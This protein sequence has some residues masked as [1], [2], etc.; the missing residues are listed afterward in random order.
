MA[1][2]PAFQFYT[3]DWLKDPNLGQCRPATRGIW[4]DL[5]CL[6]HENNKSGMIT[7]TPKSL[8]RICRATETEIRDALTDLHGTDTAD[9]QWADGEIV[10]VMNRR[11]RAED[12]LRRGG[13]ERQRKLR[14]KGGGDPKRWTAIRVPILKRDRYMCAYCGKK[15][16]TVDH[17]TPKSRGG[18]EDSWN[19]VACCK[20]CNNKKVDRT[21]EEAGMKFWPSFDKN[22]IKITPPSSSSSSS[23]PSDY[24]QEHDEKPDLAG[25]LLNAWPQIQAD[26]GLP[27]DAIPDV[28]R[29]TKNSAED[30]LPAFKETLAWA[31]E[32]YGGYDALRARLLE[33]VKAHAAG[34]GKIYSLKSL[35]TNAE[36]MGGGK[37]YHGKV[38]R[39]KDEYER[40]VPDWAK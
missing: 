9:I 37:A 26:A 27:M 5:L 35:L 40:D 31:L 32:R 20:S 19:L 38:N 22:N 7:G 36:A 28:A 3:G 1:K 8:A 18:T 39:T 17:I 23:S 10:T 11:M 16:T 30:W 25:D 33:L 15:A 29:A 24:L 6:M 14:A 21:P 12:A 2:W 4:M 13:A 34:E